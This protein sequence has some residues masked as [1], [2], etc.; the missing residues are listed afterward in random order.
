MELNIIYITHSA[1]ITSSPFN[2]HYIYR[3]RNFPNERN[4]I[5]TAHAAPSEKRVDSTAEYPII[6]CS[7][8]D[9]VITDSLGEII[10]AHKSSRSIIIHN[11]DSGRTALIARFL[12]KNRHNFPLVYTVHNS[13]E[14]FKVNKRWKTNESIFYSTRSVFCGRASYES[15]PYKRLFDQKLT[16]VPNGVDLERIDIALSQRSGAVRH[17]GDRLRVLTICKPNGQKNIPFLLSLASELHDEI[18]LTIIGPL[19]KKTKKILQSGVRK[20]VRLLGVLDRDCAI[21]EMG[22]NDVFASASFYEGLPVGVLEAMAARLP[23]VLSD[24]PPHFEILAGDDGPGPLSLDLR[25]WIKRMRELFYLRK[26]DSNQLDELG[27]RN[28]KLVEDNFS[29][30]AMHQRYSAVYVEALEALN[31]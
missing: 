13:Y 14:N 24:I 28:R 16:F 4:Y 26:V 11:H 22:R 3:K 1:G 15:Y 6:E 8:S 9:A 2:E 31:R 5:I 29:L 27:Q 10:E 25:P 17:Q 19:D 23:V 20:N 7:G 21:I 18:E 12:K 30:C